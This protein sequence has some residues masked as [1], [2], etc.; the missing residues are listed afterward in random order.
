[1]SIFSQNFGQIED[2]AQNCNFWPRWTCRGWKCQFFLK[3]WR[4]PGFSSNVVIFDHRGHVEDENFYLIK[5]FGPI[6]DFT[7]KLS[8]LTTVEMSKMKMS[9]FPKILARSRI[10]LKTVIFDHSGHVEDEYVN[11]SKN[12]SP[13]QDFISKLSFL[14]IADMSRMKISIFPKMLALSTILLKIVIFEHHGHV[15]DGKLQFFKN[16]G[17]IEDFAQNLSI[18]T[19]MGM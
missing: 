5:N 9:I 3:Y 12:I 6:Q 18:L 14:T 7:S 13:I 1:M 16:F 19:T 8:I 15:E 2:L 4:D 17:P 11:F 10:L